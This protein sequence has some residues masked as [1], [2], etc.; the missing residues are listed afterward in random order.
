MKLRAKVAALVGAR[1][2]H[3]IPTAYLE[4]LGMKHNIVEKAHN[5]ML[6][7]MA[8][9]VPNPSEAMAEVVVTAL[10][11]LTTEANLH[12]KGFAVFFGPIAQYVA[13]D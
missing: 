9:L 5:D 13:K 3:A 2:N 12:A 7:G 8:A 1:E 11:A 4:E 10:E 6:T